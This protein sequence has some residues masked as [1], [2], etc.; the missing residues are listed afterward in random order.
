MNA[1]TWILASTF[2]AAI[3]SII[4]AAWFSYKASAAAINKLVSYAIGTLLGATFFEVIPHA[5][6]TTENVHVFSGILL[7]GIL[8]FFILEKFVIWH[9][10]HTDSCEAHSTNAEQATNGRSGTM[11]LVGDTFHNFVDGILIAAAFLT[12]IR[13]GIITTIAITAHEIPQEVG[14]FLILLHS[15][16]SKKRAFVFN[17]LSSAAM[18]LGGLLAYVAFESVSDLISPFLAIA[19][20][21]MIYVAVADLIPGLHKHTDFKASIEQI[22]LILLGIATIVGASYLVHADGAGSLVH[23]H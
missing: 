9:H 14:N 10:C 4:T 5:I 3:L 13:L 11:I 12:D 19:A 20:A 23:T 22:L 2:G 8:L 17:L 15:G 6:E 1:L 16:F 7:G 21:S 18:L